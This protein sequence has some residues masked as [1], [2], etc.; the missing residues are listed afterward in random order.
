MPNDPPD[1]GFYFRDCFRIGACRDFQCL[2]I[3]F[4]HVADDVRPGG[5]V[6]S[7]DRSHDRISRD[8]DAAGFGPGAQDSI[9]KKLQ[10]F[11]LRRR[12]LGFAHGLDLLWATD[13]LRV[14]NQASFA[15][16]QDA[17]M[18]RIPEFGDQEFSS[19]R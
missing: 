13:P 3:D 7:E 18:V 1:E 19:V 5:G 2:F 12:H 10:L 17:A 4:F 6:I 14:V 11:Q 15:H 9:R 16:S 8:R